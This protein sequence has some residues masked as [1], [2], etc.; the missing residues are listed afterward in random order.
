MQRKVIIVLVTVGDHTDGAVARA[1]HS[2]SSNLGVAGV[3]GQGKMKGSAN[4]AVEG[5]SAVG[6]NIE[7]GVTVGNDRWYWVPK[8]VPPVAFD[9]SV[10]RRYVA[11]K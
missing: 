9:K 6:N 2:W 4:D 10:G 8:P 3:E 5:D 7:S 1:K 11:I